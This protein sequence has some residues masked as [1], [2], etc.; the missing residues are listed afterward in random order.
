SRLVRARVGAER[1]KRLAASVSSC[2]MRAR[3]SAPSSTYSSEPRIHRSWGPAMD[4]C[5][6]AR[7][8][9]WHGDRWTCSARWGLEIQV[10]REGAV[11]RDPGGEA[12][13]GC[14]SGAQVAGTV[15]ACAG[16]TDGVAAKEV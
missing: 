7:S 2:R 13:D 4:S 5:M 1:S 16:D 8:I 6:P 11:V 10:P 3:R 15:L 9:S 14:M 12:T